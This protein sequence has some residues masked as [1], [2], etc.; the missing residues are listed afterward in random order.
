MSLH[1]SFLARNGTS[2]ER[3]LIQGIVEPG[4]RLVVPK[5]ET[6]TTQRALCCSASRIQSGMISNLVSF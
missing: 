4:L 5:T 6:I 3:D 1:V 2:Q